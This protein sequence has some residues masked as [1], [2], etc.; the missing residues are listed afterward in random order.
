MT[1]DKNDIIHPEDKAAIATLEAVPGFT[2]L[3]KLVMSKY[4]EVQFQGMNL[5]T[6]LR[7]NEK[8][9]SEIY[10]M[11]K[12]ICGVLGIV[13]IPELYLAL[14]RSINACTYGDNKVFISINTGLLESVPSE[15]IKAVLAHECGH[16]VCRHTM[17][18]TV[19][20]LLMTGVATFI[21]DIAIEAVQLA[22]KRW[23]RMSELSADRVSALVMGSSYHVEH[24][25]KRFFG[26]VKNIPNSDLNAEEFEK[27][28]SDFNAYMSGDWSRTLQNL[29]VLNLDHP[30]TAVRILELRKWTHTPAFRRYTEKIG[31]RVCPFCGKPLATDRINR[32]CESCHRPL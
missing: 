2:K 16:I 18:S 4:S 30:L 8:Q 23:Q 22:L 11:L 13:P 12:D 29:A 21:P 1:I 15:E 20:N 28:L 7:L 6:K 17:Y 3:A 14:D 26:S 25:L 5:G 27:Q 10:N 32:F 31:V 24:L 9:F 19:A